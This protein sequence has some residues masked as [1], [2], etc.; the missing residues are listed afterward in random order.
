VKLASIYEDADENTPRGAD[1][2]AQV[3]VEPNA[4]GLAAGVKVRVPLQI[5]GVQRA[6]PHGDGT[7][8]HLHLPATLPQGAVLRLRGLGGTTKGG[9]DVAAGDL[10]VRIEIME[11]V[12]PPRWPLWLGALATAGA[13]IAALASLL[14]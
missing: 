11:K 8:V 6:D 3:Q 14:T 1:L 5:N 10:Y 7:K 4:L 2:E 9:Q 12:A 13:A